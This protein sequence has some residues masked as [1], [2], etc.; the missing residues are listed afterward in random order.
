[1][2][3]YESDRINC[4]GA[5]RLRHQINWPSLITGCI[6][7]IIICRNPAA[8]QSSG[9][10]SE[11]V[12]VSAS[13]RQD[14]SSGQEPF[15][16]EIEILIQPQPAYR[17][18]AQKW[19]RAFQDLGYAVRFREG[20]AGERTRIEDLERSG[21]RTSL[22]VGI[23]EQDGQ[24]LIVR[25]RYQ[26]AEAAKFQELAE[27]V[28]RYGAAGP[29]ASSPRWGMSEE[30]FAAVAQLLSTPVSETVSVD[31]A[32][33]I[34]HS[35]QL[36]TIFQ[37]KV[38][39]AAREHERSL[40]KTSELDGVNLKSMSKGTAMALALS[41]LGLGFRVMSGKAAGD[42]VI[43]IDRGDESTNLWP[44]GWKTKEQANVAVP[45]LYKAIPVS[46][47]DFQLTALIDVL[48]SKLQVP[49]FYSAA[50]LRAA[51]IFPAE[52]R[53]SRKPDKISP[54]KLMQLL[55]DRYQMGLDIRADEN[56]RCFLWITTR[57]EYLAF[58]NRFA[59]VIPG[60]S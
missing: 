9:L 38:T 17:I 22:I 53:Y 25:E 58:R 2:I 43:E 46:A 18:N 41:Q 39:D 31:S 51:G 7:M 36:P 52:I 34:V 6:V 19:G 26:L 60:K 5:D 55:G 50:S 12:A 33:G 21:G 1:M 49:H 45:A 54:M 3:C 23:L 15:E 35:L 13:S 44:V 24:I 32:S 59:H 37:V 28:R 11:I 40:K 56:G 14:T 4:F 10:R 29:P 42:Y 48:S 57:A 8:A 30:Q 47:E 16:L 20:R 27:Q